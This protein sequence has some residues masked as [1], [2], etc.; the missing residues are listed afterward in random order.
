MT[1]TSSTGYW[2]SPE[3]RALMWGVNLELL[4]DY[5]AT[6]E[7][8]IETARGEYIEQS[9]NLTSQRVRQLR[10]DM[11]AGKQ[12][13]FEF[14]EISVEEQVADNQIQLLDHFHH[15]WRGS[16]F[17][18][19]YADF[20]SSLNEECRFWQGTDVSLQLD[21]IK[22]SATERAVIY[23]EKVLKFTFPKNSY[24]GDIHQG[25]RVLRNCIVH[26]AGSLDKEF[27]E[28]AKLK[29]FIEREDLLSLQGS[30]VILHKAFVIRLLTP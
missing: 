10:E 9:K 26:N 27:S 5:L 23:W 25:Y 15:M 28:G 1:K 18:T 3:F 24:W 22:G 7:N 14:Q 21:E 30:S 16:F 4:Q 12:V 11:K 6:M 2:S 19:L 20:E 13:D 17:I 29:K 8:F